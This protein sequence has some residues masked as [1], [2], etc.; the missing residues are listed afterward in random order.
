MPSK[1]ANDCE[2]PRHCLH[3]GAHC[4]HAVQKSLAASTKPRSNGARIAAGINVVLLVIIII[5]HGGG[6]G[7]H[8]DMRNT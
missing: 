1:L 4:D 3:T 7:A 8:I 6:G 2:T 5:I